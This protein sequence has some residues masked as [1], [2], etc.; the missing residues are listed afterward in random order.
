M[1]RYSLSPKE[2]SDLHIMLSALPFPPIAVHIDFGENIG[3]SAK[4]R[5]AFEVATSA[6]MEDSRKGDKTVNSHS[7]IA[8]MSLFH[9]WSGRFQ[10]PKIDACV[11]LAKEGATLELVGAILGCKDAEGAFACADADAIQIFFET[12]QKW[13]ASYVPAD[14]IL[15]VRLPAQQAPAKREDPIHISMAHYCYAQGV[16]YSSKGSILK[17]EL[18]VKMEQDIQDRIAILEADPDDP[19]AANTMD[20]A[21]CRQLGMEMAEQYSKHP[22]EKLA[23]LC[24]KRLYK[25]ALYGYKDVDTENVHANAL[26]LLESARENY[27]KV[28]AAVGAHAEMSSISEGA[29][30][31]AEDQAA[32]LTVQEGCDHIELDIVSPSAPPEEMETTL[33]VAL[34]SLDIGSETVAKT[35]LPVS[36]RST[37]GL[38]V[39]EISFIFTEYKTPQPADMGRWRGLC[40]SLEVSIKTLL[41]VC[42]WAGARVCTDSL[43]SSLH[44]CAES[45]RNVRRRQA[46][47]GAGPEANK[48]PAD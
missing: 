13:I 41:R 14:T 18:H 28:V 30:D 48:H 25:D 46:R 15:T 19:T 45:C 47:N 11:K 6:L 29:A 23:L 2:V 42:V 26:G 21:S 44:P 7:V 27:I 20:N 31:D 38:W 10:D 40:V 34:S 43:L 4:Y 35:A 32:C 39:A 16:L 9:K 17:C 33:E 36:Y 22:Y 3:K 8:A 1:L 37:L 24:A 5:D 12:S